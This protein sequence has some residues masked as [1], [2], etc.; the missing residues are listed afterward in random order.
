MDLSM[1]PAELSG[2]SYHN[3]LVYHPQLMRSNATGKPIFSWNFTV[4]MLYALF[5]NF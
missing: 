1:S 2:T 3:L 5:K 4:M